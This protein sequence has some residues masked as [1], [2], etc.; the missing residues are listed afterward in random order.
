MWLRILGLKCALYWK[1]ILV[2]MHDEQCNSG[3]W[4]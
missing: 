3:T 2:G 4:D 1:E